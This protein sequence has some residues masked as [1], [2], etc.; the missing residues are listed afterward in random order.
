M[1]DG[2]E[3]KMEEYLSDV[4]SGLLLAFQRYKTL[5]IEDKVGKEIQDDFVAERS[6]TKTIV[7]DDLHNR[8]HLATAIA[9]LDFS[10]KGIT[11]AHYKQAK[12]YEIRRTVTL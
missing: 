4:R 2:K 7:S 12:E 6:K 10:C 1:N 5:K 11:F 3:A 9:A 8:I